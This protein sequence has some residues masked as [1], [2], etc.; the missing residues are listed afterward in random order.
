LTEKQ[1]NPRSK[2][3]GTLIQIVDYDP[4][5]HLVDIVRADNGDPVEQSRSVATEVSQSKNYNVEDKRILKVG[6]DANGSLVEVTSG[7][8]RLAGN[9]DNG[10]FS[11]KDDGNNIIKG[12]LSIVAMPNQIRLSGITTLN[13]LLLSGF[14]STVV[15]PMP[16][17]I[18]NIPGVK[19]V[20]F[21]MKSVATMGTLLSACG[22]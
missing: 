17:C 19:A 6:D 10:F 11:Y 2:Y 1:T 7:Y 12:P 5:K 16:V 21:L 8:A 3:S 14:P 22:S 4:E 18:L 9:R 20:Q 13:P 15:S